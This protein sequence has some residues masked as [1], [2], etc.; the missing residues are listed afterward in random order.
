MYANRAEDFKI[1]LRKNPQYLSLTTQNALNISPSIPS[2]SVS[3]QSSI[4]TTNSNIQNETLAAYVDCIG[5]KKWLIENK[6]DIEKKAQEIIKK[7]PKINV[8]FF[9]NHTLSMATLIPGP[10]ESIGIYAVL[11]HKK[12]NEARKVKRL[13]TQT[14]K[15][16]LQ[17]ISMDRNSSNNRFNEDEDHIVI[18]LDN[19]SKK[20]KNLICKLSL[21]P[22]ETPFV[23]KALFKLAGLSTI[24]Q[25]IQKHVYTFIN[26]NIFPLIKLSEQSAY[27]PIEGKSFEF[28]HETLSL[29]EYNNRTL[30]AMA[31][32]ASSSDYQGCILKKPTD[33]SKKTTEYEVII[34]ESQKAETAPADRITFTYEDE[35]LQ[36]ECQEVL[37][38]CDHLLA[39]P[40]HPSQ[41]KNTPV[42]PPFNVIH[43]KRANKTIDS[44]KLIFIK[45]QPN[46]NNKSDSK[47]LFFTKVF[48]RSANG[49]DETYLIESNTLMIMKQSIKELPTL[50]KGISSSI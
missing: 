29:E 22:P 32:K 30:S 37:K 15:S 16:F 23:E 36:K 26:Y 47:P 24:T 7:E 13:K 21:C 1:Y 42:V 44:K 40:I 10:K 27:T 41:D 20:L 5:I 19:Y 28:I 8:E 50:L 17:R 25:Y 48:M 31:Q 11:S 18:Y 3:S 14:L 2:F 39:I 34:M 38:D 9:Q 43:L 35:R 4:Q 45:N 33:T 12:K 46:T 49:K 6:S